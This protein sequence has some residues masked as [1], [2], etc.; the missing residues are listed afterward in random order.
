MLSVFD[1]ERFIIDVDKIEKLNYLVMCIYMYKYEDLENLLFYNNIMY[2][3]Y[4]V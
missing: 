2:I 4:N 3:V 1:D